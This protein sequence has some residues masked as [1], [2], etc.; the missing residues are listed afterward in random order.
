MSVMNQ[1]VHPEAV[2]PQPPYQEND[3]ID[4]RELFAALAAR[5]WTIF[6]LTALVLL[7]SAAYAIF[8]TPIYS[9]DALV[10]V[11][12]KKP[13]LPLF[14]QLAAMD[15]SGA[16]E[17]EAEIEIIKSRFVLGKVVD[18][19][20]LDIQVQPKTFPL[21]GRYVFRTYRPEADEPPVRDPWL[22]SRW[23]WGG[24]R[25]QLS[26]LNVPDDWMDQNLVLRKT[27][28]DSFELLA[29]DEPVIQGRVGEFIQQG[30]WAIKVEQLL[31]HDGVR[32]AVSKLS[33]YQ[34]ISNLLDQL[35]VKERGK[36]TGVIEL[37]YQD[38]DAARARAILNEITQVYYDQNVR[39]LSQEAANSI[40]FIKTRLP[41]LRR[42]LTEAEVA[43][44][45]F[46]QQQG[47]VAINEETKAV[48][49]RLTEVERK[50]QDIDLKEA[51]FSKRFRTDYPI[52]RALIEQ[53]DKLQAE[54]A[55]IEKQIKKFPDR[56]QELIRLTR[57]VQIAND[58]YTQLLA[59]QQELEVVE[60]STVG[61]VRILDQAVTNPKPVKPKKPLIVAIGGLLG[62]MLGV[63]VVLVQRMLR[64]EIHNVAQLE[65][66]TGRPVYATI[67]EV[68]ALVKQM[69]RSRSKGEK[70]PLLTE[71]VVNDD[72]A[73]ESFRSLRTAVHFAL[74][75]DARPVLAITGPAP[76]VGKTFTS[77]HLGLV[78]AQ[79]EAKVLLVDADMRKG[80]IERYFGL[81]R[82]P[83]LSEVL[84]GDLPWRSALHRL[85][86]NDLHLLTAGRYP[87]NP[88]ELLMHPR[89]QALLDEARE[90]F[91]LVIVDTPPVLAVTDAVIITHLAGATLLVCR[92][93]VT[94]Y[95]E[96][97]AA[98]ARLAQNGVNVKGLIVNALDTRSRYGYRYGNRYYYSASRYRYQASA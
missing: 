3:E 63:G 16:F 82:S 98:L 43:L 61:N 96:A 36:K 5:K 20:G 69:R 14:D 31:G 40:A 21:I 68:P 94:E 52:Y 64:Q 2:L 97:T 56:Q 75:D 88:A 29:D 62:L 47:T 17:S 83:G 89:F 27:G 76:S 53:K 26:L 13:S 51:E 79:S 58:V 38:P 12:K 66:T 77:V 7:L 11:E 50:L 23:A 93:G 18:S 67:P 73:L 41:E 71:T 48:I 15:P 32:F 8:A 57:D 37:S 60:A 95:G 30:P 85:G 55:A 1:Q 59:K 90:T 78:A 80:H 45:R 10:Q 22:S 70:L 84:A 19:L 65:E 92:A 34:A 39:R 33:P 87:P 81:S 25:A 46:R 44:N 4:L 9:S 24:E 6:S 42:Q 91:D 54:R 49:E 35:T 28:A 72:P 86:P 74:L